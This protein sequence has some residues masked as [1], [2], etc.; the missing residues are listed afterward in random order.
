MLYRFGLNTLNL[1]FTHQQLKNSQTILSIS[2]TN[3]GS[4]LRFTPSHESTSCI[5]FNTT[6]RESALAQLK[7][8]LRNPAQFAETTQPLS[9]KSVRIYI[10]VILF[11]HR[12]A[13]SLIFLEFCILRILEHLRIKTAPK[14]KNLC[15]KY[16]R[17]FLISRE[18]FRSLEIGV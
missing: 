16:F 13:A 1:E 4:V 14:Q 3:P 18:L 6:F 2:Y 9:R 10:Q 12:R 8:P 7:A 17:K 5:L 15:L 11:A